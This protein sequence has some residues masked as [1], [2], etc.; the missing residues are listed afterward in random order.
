MV[1]E[2]QQVR[3]APLTNF[4]DADIAEASQRLVQNHSTLTASSRVLLQ[5]SHF[6]LILTC[7]STLSTSR[8]LTFTY[9]FVFY[10]HSLEAVGALGSSGPVQVCCGRQARGHAHVLRLRQRAPRAR[11]QLFAALLL[12]L[13]TSLNQ[14]DLERI[15]SQH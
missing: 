2:E 12:A 15:R 14:T 7:T 13:R 3:V 9:P 1:F 5:A 6:A 4:P 11:A 10:S 8:I